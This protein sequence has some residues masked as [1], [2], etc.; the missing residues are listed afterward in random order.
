MKL[1][2]FS[3][4][5]KNFDMYVSKTPN[6]KVPLLLDEASAHGQ[7]ED[8]PALLNVEVIFLRKIRT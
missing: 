3:A 1:F 7:I 8:L 2:Y 4:W 5:L 6:G